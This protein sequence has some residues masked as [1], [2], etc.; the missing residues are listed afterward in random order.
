MNTAETIM[1]MLSAPI[2]FCLPYIIQFI[3]EKLGIESP[4]I[5]AFL[6]FIVS[7]AAGT[8]VVCA[9]GQIEFSD[10]FSFKN[11]GTVLIAH[12]VVYSYS[13]MFYHNYLKP[14]LEAK[15]NGGIKVGGSI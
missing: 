2:I 11:T 6:G 7:I 12:S 9:T 1:A 15:K 4:K 14:K 5:K 3:K 8:T 10:L 13:N